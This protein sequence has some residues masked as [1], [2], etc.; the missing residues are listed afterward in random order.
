MTSP[1]RPLMIH[2]AMFESCVRQLFVFVRSL[3]PIMEEHIIHKV[4]RQIA[5]RY[6]CLSHHMES[7]R[8][9]YALVM[10]GSIGCPMHLT[11]F[12]TF[13][14]QMIVTN[15]IKTK[16]SFRQL[17]YLFILRSSAYSII[18]YSLHVEC[19]SVEILSSSTP[20]C[21]CQVG[22]ASSEEL[23]SPRLP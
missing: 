16:S 5:L 2:I 17:Y 6:A 13:F 19:P 12:L 4:P 11:I 7:A 20:P 1:Q 14:L 8:L 15:D 10:G 3:Q 22:R 21:P 23:L 18:R 9:H